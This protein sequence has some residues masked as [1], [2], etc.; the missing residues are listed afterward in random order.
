MTRLKQAI[1]LA[2]II[3]K[4]QVD[5]AGVDYILHP[6]SVSAR[7]KT[8]S[9]KIVAVLHDTLEDGADKEYILKEVS[10]ILTKAEL[11]A[12]LLLT[13]RPDM[14]YAEY[15]EEIMTCEIAMEVKLA[16]LE[17]NLREDRGDI[18]T[19]LRKRYEKSY[20]K[21]KQETLK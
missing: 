21:I 1:Q 19:S 20:L 12:L 6:L 17:E 18:P 10:K 3:H 2:T 8:E 14:T 15:I 4:G 5:K 16:D 9:A 7:C 11:K 13:K